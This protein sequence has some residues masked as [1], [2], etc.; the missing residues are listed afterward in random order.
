MQKKIIKFFKIVNEVTLFS[1]VLKTG[2]TGNTGNTGNTGTDLF[3]YWL[4]RSA[5]GQARRGRDMIGV[6]T[7]L[8]NIASL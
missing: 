4:C 8:K 7:L 6:V 1:P 3:L 5:T 2:S